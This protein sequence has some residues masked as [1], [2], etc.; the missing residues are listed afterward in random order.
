MTF[1]LKCSKCGIELPETNLQESHDVPCYMFEGA[2]RKEKKNKADKYG[3]RRLCKKCH[4]IYEKTLPA[5]LFKTLGKATQ[6][7]LRTLAKY[8]A[9]KYFQKRGDN[10]T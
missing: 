6:E 7:R 1:T 5:Y 3:R 9:N 10:D 4:D 8:F 2:N